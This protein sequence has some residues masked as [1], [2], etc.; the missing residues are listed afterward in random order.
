MPLLG[1]HQLSSLTETS[2]PSFPLKITKERVWHWLL[3]DLAESTLSSFEPAVLISHEL[4][5]QPDSESPNETL[6]PSFSSISE[7]FTLPPTRSSISEPFTVPPTHSSNSET[8]SLPRTPEKQQAAALIYKSQKF[9]IIGR[10]ACGIIF[11]QADLG[12]VLKIASSRLNNLWND[13]VAHMKVIRAFNNHDLQ[14]QIPAVYSFN[15]STDKSWWDRHIEKFPTGP[16]LPNDALRTQRIPPLPLLVRN[17]L[18][19]LFCP[20]EMVSRAKDDE[21]NRDCLVHLYLGSRR[22]SKARSRVFTLR[23][24]NLHLDQLE[25]LDMD[26]FD[27]A[28]QMADA[29]AVIH[30]DAH[31]DG[32]DIEFVLGSGAAA[33]GQPKVES[34]ECLSGQQIPVSAVWRKGPSHSHSQKRI[35]RIW[36][37]DFDQC[38]H[39]TVDD[40]GVKDAVEAFYLNEPYYPRPGC[41]N[42][43]DQVLWIVFCNRYLSKSYE[44][45]GDGA[46]A[47][48]LPERFIQEVVVQASAETRRRVYTGM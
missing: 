48:E 19:D 47:G 27:Y 1:G 23:N 35:V 38:R 15:H 41:T 40:D 46:G 17:A 8:F 14:I 13:C 26:A 20:P 33:F 25:D 16:L 9:R 39:M 32:R 37:L 44:I 24:M 21:A 45:L 4:K 5:A 34:K 30:W 36:V 29:L 31:L 7:T 18:I 3:Q 2:P 12:T 22:V 10:G 6:T 11:E 42:R 43:Q 28:E